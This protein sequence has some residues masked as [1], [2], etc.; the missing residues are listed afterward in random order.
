FALAD[1]RFEQP[2]ALRG[3][4]VRGTLTDASGGRLK[5]IAWRAQETVMGERLLASGGALHVAGRLKFDDW[6]G[7][8]SVQFEIEDVADP[9]M[10]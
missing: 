9:R 1:V 5:A 2:M 7:R 10:R 8:E 4:H 3:G 6:N